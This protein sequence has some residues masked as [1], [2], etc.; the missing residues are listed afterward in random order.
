M[1]SVGGRSCTILVVDDSTE[2]RD[3]YGDFI[4]AEGYEVATASNGE[5][6]PKLLFAPVDPSC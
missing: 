1:M 6:A 5:E 3:L 4:E 2:I